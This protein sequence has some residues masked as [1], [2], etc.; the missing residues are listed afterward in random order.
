MYRLRGSDLQAAGLSLTNL[1]PDHLHAA[2]FPGGPLPQT[3]GPG[4]PPALQEM[5][6]MVVDGDDGRFDAQDY[7]VFYAEGAHGLR[8]TSGGPEFNYNP[9][10]SVN[11]VFI[12]IRGE[13]GLRVEPAAAMSVE[14]PVINT[15]RDVKFY[16][17]PAINLLSSG[18][19]WYGDVIRSGNSQS[20]TF[21]FPDP[22]PDGEI[23]ITSAVMAQSFTQAGFTV[24]WNG[25]NLGEQTITAVP[26]FKDPPSN[27]PFEFS[28]KGR[29]NISTFTTTQD[30][31]GTGTV[32][33]DYEGGGSTTSDGYI[34]YL[35]AEADRQISISGNSL[36][37]NGH[38]TGR[39]ELTYS[40]EAPL[41]WDISDFYGPQE[42]NTEITD[43]RIR[44]G[45]T[46]PGNHYYAAFYPAS[47]PVP[48]QDRAVP[49]QD[50]PGSMASGLLIITH[51]DFLD[52]AMKLAAHRASFDNLSVTVATTEEI[53]NE[54]AGGRQ[55]VSALRNFARELFLKGELE[56]V[57]LFGKGTYDYLG[58]LN[59]TANFVPVYQS[60]NSLEPLSSYAS[61]DFYGFLEEGEGA[62]EET[63]GGNHTLETGVGRLP[64]T[65]LQQAMQVVDKIMHYDLGEETA[66]E[67]RSR[68][69]F[70][71]DDEDFNLH[72]RQAERLADYADTTYRSFRTRKIYLGAF[73]QESGAGGQRIPEA[74]KAIDD[75][76]WQGSLV[77]NYT[78]H[79]GEDGWAQER[80]LT[81]QMIRE[82][83]NRDKLPLFVTATCEFGRHDNPREVSGG[84][85]VITEP[86]GGGI[87]LLSTGRPVFSSSNFSVNRAFYESV[88]V[89]EDGRA[90]T[91]GSIF[92]RT[93][94]QSVD[95]AID[96]DR[97]GNRNFTLL[98]DPS[99]RIALP[100]Q[101][102]RIS[103]ISDETGATDTLKSGA[104]IRM[105][106]EVLTSGG[107][108]DENWSGT[109]DIL[110]TDK[111][112]T[113]QTIADPAFNYRTREN[114]IF[115]GEASVS[116]GLGVFEFIVPRNISQKPGTGRIQLFAVS[117]QQNALGSV[118]SVFVGGTSEV[119]NTDDNGPEIMVYF[120]DSTNA[121]RT[122]VNDNTL[123]FIRLQD[124]SGIN[125]SGFGIGNNLTATVDDNTYVLNEYFTAVKDNYRE[126]WAA[127]PLNDLEKGAHSLT[128]RA[129]DVY[130]NPTELSV[131]FFVADPGSIVLK[132]VLNYPQPVA[133]QTRIRFDHNRAGETLDVEWTL[134]GGQGQILERQS[135]RVEDSPSRVELLTWENGNGSK[136]INPGIYF[137]SVVVRSTLDGA[138]AKKY[139]KL[140]LID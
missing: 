95:D 111:P 65:T 42:I 60:R 137:Y 37:F 29:E 72:H 76:I 124:E 22:D 140:I 66:G 69:A 28:V 70:V 31:N 131:E 88:F 136:Y 80:V 34:N 40:G 6:I 74:N 11:Y 41:L 61:D 91:F 106:A 104:R 102:I 109:A 38:Q 84:E 36:L 82:W 7:L 77:L 19:T 44:F 25:N 2:A 135:L 78:G 138:S 67:W 43:T 79:G 93:K 101:R 128:I 55:D 12:G 85:L 125:V 132:N 50:L 112:I 130:N 119:A 89:P 20:V 122:D 45:E 108:R 105:E 116:N 30:G 56:N 118:D 23:I 51:P 14:T 120:G 8:E 94:N 97:V 10:A 107:I 39:Y 86:G 123:L 87:A 1:N 63:A 53:Y 100:E 115:K 117:D 47:L 126:G 62:W 18:R 49:N 68:L 73:K 110:V 75:L 46:R 71:A 24:S 59:V 121:S 114:I 26:D 58:L 83:Q 48:A 16:K 96:V 32:R 81:R 99:Q 57:L 90:P 127:F 133:D 4:R 54:Y 129:W 64:V 113:R 13:P 3:L 17:D 15:F 134:I 103:S 27:N 92:R 21:N 52:A 5:A 35:L 98:G 33:L 9:Y 139:Q